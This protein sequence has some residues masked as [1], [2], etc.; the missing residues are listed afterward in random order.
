MSQPRILVSSAAGRTGA[1]AAHELLRRGFPVR[2]FVHRRDACA[3][4]LRQAGAEAVVGD[5]YD[6]RDIER[7]RPRLGPRRFTSDGTKG[8]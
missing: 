4:V 2:A 7:A 1:V 8:A 6:F 5:L 3:E